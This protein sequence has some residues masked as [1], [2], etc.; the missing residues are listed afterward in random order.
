MYFA[1]SVA[2]VTCLAMIAAVLFFPKIKIGKF[3]I[4]SYWL[5][6]LLGAAV[7][8]ISGTVNLKSVCSA[9]VADRSINPVKILVLFISMTILSVFLDEVFSDA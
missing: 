4:S 5:I 8:L 2:A 3:A 1:I 9:L 7:L 6:T